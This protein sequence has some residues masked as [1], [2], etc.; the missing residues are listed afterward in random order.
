MT[1]TIKT[2][3][4][5]SGA[6]DVTLS[7]KGGAPENQV[8][9][10][11]PADTRLAPRLIKFMTSTP[12]TTAANPGN[13]RSTVRFILGNRVEEEGCCT[14]KAGTVTV[15]LIVNWPLTQPDSLVDEAIGL[16][17]GLA[18]SPALPSLIKDGVLPS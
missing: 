12:V 7:S 8:V 10:R 13:A 1:L 18:Y 2:G 11:T 5:Q 3:G 15:D 6:T 4:T 14:V 17:Q 16:I 9:L